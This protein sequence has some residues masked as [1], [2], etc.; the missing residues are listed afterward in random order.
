M[1]DSFDGNGGT[2][3]LSLQ[4]MM[5]SVIAITENDCAVEKEMRR[6]IDGQALLMGERRFAFEVRNFERSTKVVGLHAH[7]AAGLSSCSF[8]AF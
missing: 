2:D 3:G 8:V 7:T 6:M 4:P 5:Q 1:C